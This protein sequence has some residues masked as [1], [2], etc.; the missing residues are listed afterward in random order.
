MRLSMWILADWLAKYNP[1]IKIENGEQVLRSARIL[2]AETRMEA[3]NVYLARADQFAAGSGNRVICVHEGDSLLLDTEDMG[4][5]FNEVLD[6]FDFYN[7]WADGLERDILDGC[8]LQ[9]LLDQSDPVFR[10]PL[11]VFDAGHMVIAHSSRY[12]PDALDEEWN[13]M[14]QTGS[15]S[16]DI[17][18]EMKEHLHRA[19]YSHEVTELRYSFFAKHS[20]QRMLFD[21]QSVIGQI[22]L[23]EWH[24]PAG[25][26]ARQLLD[27]LGSL[28]ELW[29][30]HTQ[31]EQLL[32]PEC[33]IFRGLL[34]GKAVSGQEVNYRL[35]MM[36]WE[37][38]HEKLLL[39][40]EIP[41]ADREI[42]HPLQARLERRL[43]DCYVFLHQGAVYVL[44]NQCFTPWE[45]V[46]RELKEL[47]KKCV[48][49]CAVSYPFTDVM[50]LS[51]AAGQCR[52]TL[53]AAL[54]K[55]G[56]IY[57]CSDYALDYIRNTIHAQIDA[58][59]VHPALNILKSFD[60]ETQNDLYATLRAYLRNNC[61]L[62]RTANTLN[63]HRNSLLYRLNRIRDLTAIDLTA[64]D[65]REYLLLSYII[66]DGREP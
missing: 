13:T 59:A 8:E 58:A 65:V 37:K 35:S 39:K 49:H 5:V 33:D 40:I 63:L 10:E 38:A 17:L 44:L 9:H 14:L 25:K 57:H 26:G 29:M 43:P 55:R 62:S 12:G 15:N 23:I 1:A 51:A 41:T 4:A 66:L 36:G 54:E 52:L 19:R 18:N 28:M 48:L 31:R 20:L 24:R 42:A 60:A 34:D 50:K 53:Q 3:Q 61:N 46:E 22:I 27:A 56:G 32:K 6:A 11:I 64:E 2:S 47:L 7:A 30:R 21:D 45:A 16:F